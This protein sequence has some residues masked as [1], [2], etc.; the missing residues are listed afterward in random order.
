MNAI[1]QKN[2]SCKMLYACDWLEI[3]SINVFS[4]ICCSYGLQFDK[5][6]TYLYIL[7]YEIES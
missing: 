1:L 2:L 5:H 3:I 7:G 4:F 6:T